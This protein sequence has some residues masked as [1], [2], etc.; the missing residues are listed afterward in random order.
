MPARVFHN[1]T[2]Q[3]EQIDKD[4]KAQLDG[5]PV[6]IGRKYVLAMPT[7]GAKLI[8]VLNSRG[9]YHMYVPVAV[10]MGKECL[11]YA[12]AEHAE[13]AKDGAMVQK[14]G[15]IAFCESLEDENADSLLRDLYNENMAKGIR[16]RVQ[17]G[18]PL[19]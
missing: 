15:H 5:Q 18:S 6:K 13:R 14:S 4:L 19:S 10:Y 9:F 16:P 1:H 11:G 2:G 17:V 7:N 8:V 3:A 12:F